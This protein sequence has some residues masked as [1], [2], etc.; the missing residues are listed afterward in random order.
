MKLIILKKSQL[1]KKLKTKI[2]GFNELIY[3]TL[4]V[5]RIIHLKMNFFSI[6]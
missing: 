6:L 4:I 1:E 3:Y 5:F 2:Q